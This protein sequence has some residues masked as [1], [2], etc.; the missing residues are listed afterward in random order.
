MDPL[1][2]K[3]TGPVARGAH[4]EPRLLLALGGPASPVGDAHPTLQDRELRAAELVSGPDARSLARFPEAGAALLAALS[5]PRAA[6]EAPPKADAPGGAR[7]PRD[8]PAPSAAST[9]GP[10]LAPA[11]VPAGPLAV[12]DPFAAGSSLA[13]ALQTA[14][15]FGAGVAGLAPASLAPAGQGPGPVR[16]AAPV[17]RLGNLQAHSGRPGPEAFPHP[18]VPVHRAPQGYPTALPAPQA[19]QLDL[20]A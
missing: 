8:L 20:L 16:D 19:G 4:S 13:F 5:A 2:V 14:L 15:R 9:P 12:T 1:A 18:Q 6:T 7:A 11:T 17:P 3:A 10:V